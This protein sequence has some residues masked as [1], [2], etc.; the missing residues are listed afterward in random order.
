MLQNLH[1]ESLRIE[2]VKGVDGRWGFCYMEERHKDIIIN[3][4][5]EGIKRI[6]WHVAGWRH[7][8]AN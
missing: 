4:F 7:K 2:E 8:V 1:L 3:K 5:G 6:G